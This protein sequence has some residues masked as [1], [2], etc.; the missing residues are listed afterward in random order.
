MD[1]EL[2]EKYMKGEYDPSDYEMRRRAKKWQDRQRTAKELHQ[3]FKK[4][5]EKYGNTEL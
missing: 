3:Q 5:N 1:R 2:Y 4:A